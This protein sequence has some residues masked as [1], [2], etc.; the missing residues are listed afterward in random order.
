MTRREIALLV[1]A[2]TIIFLALL[3]VDARWTWLHDHDAPWWMYLR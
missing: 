2:L 3:L 1:M